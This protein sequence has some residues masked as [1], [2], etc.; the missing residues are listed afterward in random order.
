MEP[1]ISKN[2]FNYLRVIFLLIAILLSISVS[3]TAQTISGPYGRK[4]KVHVGD[5]AEYNYTLLTSHGHNYIVDLNQLSNGTSINLNYTVGTLNYVKL[6]AL[7]STVGGDVSVYTQGTI[8]LQGSGTFTTDISQYTSYIQQ[9]FTNKSMV[10]LYIN[11]T[12]SSYTPVQKNSTLLY[13][14][15]GYLVTNASAIIAN[16]S[17]IINMAYNWRTGWMKYYEL[18]VSYQNGTVLY[19]SIQEMV[20]YPIQNN[21]P[22]YIFYGIVL[23]ITIIVAVIGYIVLNN[24][25]KI[26]FDLKKGETTIRYNNEKNNAEKKNKNEQLTIKSIDKSM[27][28]LDEIMDESKREMKK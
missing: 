15:N 21:S 13:E 23:C 27:K 2:C 8:I 4:Y 17:W 1:K 25:K 7:N 11:R 10:D 18:K 28:I 5:S 20:G 19:H 9:A 6:I 3:V 14:K 22:N 26:K 12:I 24:K 16:Q